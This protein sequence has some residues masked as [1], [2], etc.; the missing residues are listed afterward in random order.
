MLKNSKITK[1]I[2]LLVCAGIIHGWSLFAQY[3]GGAGYGAG[4]AAQETSCSLVS[5]YAGLGGDGS[6]AVSMFQTCFANLFTNGGNGAGFATD[7]VL[8][9]CTLPAPY[10]GG[11][12]DGYGVRIN[13]LCPADSVVA[14]VV[15][16]QQ[17]SC[18]SGDLGIAA[19]EIIDG[20]PNWLSIADFTFTWKNGSGTVIREVTKNTR[21]DTITG[22][23][24]DQYTLVVTDAINKNDSVIFYINDCLYRGGDGHGA[25][26]DSIEKAC[27]GLSLFAGSSGDGFSAE[28]DLQT[29]D[30][31]LFSKGGNGNG[32]AL[33]TSL[34]NCPVP[35][36]FSGGNADGYGNDE[37]VLF[38][39]FRLFSVGGDGSGFNVDTATQNC[40]PVSI[41]AGSGNDGFAYDTLTDE[42]VSRM[43]SSGGSGNGF[44]SD[45]ALQN[46]RPLSVFGGT[47]GD[48]FDYGAEILLCESV[49]F[50]RGGSGAGFS[51]DT[52]LSDCPIPDI[53]GGDSGDGYSMAANVPCLADS[54]VID[55]A[56][57]TQITCPLTIDNGVAS[58]SIIEGFPD[59]RAVPDFTYTWK[60]SAGTVMPGYPVTK[61]DM[62]DTIYNLGVDDYT[63][64][65][66]DALGNTDSI[67]VYIN[68]CLYRGGVG[69]GA[70]ADSM[71]T[72][73]LPPSIFSGTGNDGFGFNT[74]TSDCAFAL[75]SMGGNGNGF[76]TDT[77]LQECIPLNVF[78]GSEN[79]GFSHASEI[80]DCELTYFT[81]GGSGQGFSTDTALQNCLLPAYTLGEQGDGADQE[82]NGCT[83]YIYDYPSNNNNCLIADTISSNGSNQWQNIMKDGQLVAAVRDNGNSL[84][85]ITTQFYVND[86][87]VRIDPF[88]IL[89]SYYLDR[90][91]KIS[92]ENVIAGSPV[93]VRLYF[94]TNEYQ[95]LIDADNNVSSFANLGI[96]KYN[97]TNEDCSLTNNVDNNDN[98]NYTH[99]TNFVWEF[100]ENGYFLEFDVNSF[101]EFY[102]NNS[103]SL[104][105]PYSITADLSVTS[106]YNGADISCNGASDGEATVTPTYGVAPFLYQWND[107]LSQNDSIASG[108]PAGTWTI[109]IFDANNTV[110]IDS[111]TITEPD[112]ISMT[113]L[114][115]PACEDKND[116]IA[117]I[118]AAGGTAPYTYF[119]NTFDGSGLQATDEDQ[120]TLSGG[121]YYV[122]ITDVNSCTY[123][124]SVTISENPKSVPPTGITVA[125]DNT[126]PG[127]TKSLTP[128]GGGLGYNAQWRWYSDA[129]CTNLLH[130]GNVYD[131]DPAVT[132]SYWLRAEGDCDTTVAVSNTVNVLVL[133][134]I[135]DGILRSDNNVAP[136]TPVTLVIDGGTLGAGAGDW[137]WYL[138][139]SGTTSAGADN[140]TLVVSPMVTTQYW[141]R[142]EGTCNTTGM[143][144]ITVTINP[145]PLKP[146]T[147]TGTDTLCQNA[148]NTIYTTAGAAGATSY[149]WSI[150]PAAAGTITG[151]GT[152]ATVDWAEDYYEAVSITVT[153]VNA[154]GSGPVSDPLEIW[155]WK[156]PETGS[157]YHISNDWME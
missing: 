84:G 57:I 78:A 157:T 17:K 131:V 37:D 128:L 25:A 2:F 10:Q 135:P 73:C 153:G 35:N 70:A 139:A 34:N 116:G 133:S 3:E 62:A 6:D 26:S 49:L 39:E 108:L 121:K 54:L 127:V 29:C 61:A 89:P 28:A 155:L 138:D 51:Q 101:S 106:D 63:I 66:T 31:Y 44:A 91:Y 113:S 27:N 75:F 60:N 144:T 96:T 149:S 65:V 98:L 129:G 140:D 87:P 33:D 5:I 74:D 147:P 38:C 40:A 32:F 52:A 92:T 93:R 71:E 120:Y 72:N 154:S 97:G 23:D 102:I 81:S 20:Y 45:S 115:T 137:K 105:E 126:C 24:V 79:D 109:T 117:D 132:T 122:E 55:A 47:A 150:S 76:S 53:F 86:N 12:G 43:F 80:L 151:T 14:D 107:P 48:G 11:N 68:D 125:N 146:A 100:Y 67:T 56:V 148:A 82:Y 110:Y 8:N 64:V 118:T 22:I 114:V 142:A 15:I 104:P 59:W 46:C 141:A 50:T 103:T 85:E 41:F 19:A 119:W 123:N 130:T 136:G 90:N 112:T 36:L 124:D 16:L 99:N 7:T 1:R 88:G 69:F 111:I 18:T 13:S 94:L 143:V 156:T 134:V 58:V 152:S 30:F 9:T 77:A 4:N 42:C 83:P 95:A 21:Y 145:L